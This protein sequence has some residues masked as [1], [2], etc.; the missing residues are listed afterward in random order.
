MP[1]YCGLCVALV[2][3]CTWFTV[4]PDDTLFMQW[5][6]IV[7]SWHDLPEGM[8]FTCT[9]VFAC[10]SALVRVERPSRGRRGGARLPPHPLTSFHQIAEDESSDEDVGAAAPSLDVLDTWQSGL[11]V[12]DLCTSASAW[13]DD[14]VDIDLDNPGP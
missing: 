2:I 7:P 8:L 13:H 9:V 4:P 3:G 12:D 14:S 5:C 1:G 11:H 10:F 6:S